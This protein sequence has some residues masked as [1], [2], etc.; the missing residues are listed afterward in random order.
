MV[1]IKYDII[2]DEDNFTEIMSCISEV[3]DGS[4]K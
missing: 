2:I 3:D 4:E 1:D